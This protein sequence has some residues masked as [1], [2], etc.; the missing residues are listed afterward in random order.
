MAKQKYLPKLLLGFV[1]IVGESLS[2]SPIIV[3][4]EKNHGYG[5]SDLLTK[6]IAK[7]VYDVIGNT[8]LFGVSSSKH[9]RSSIKK[10]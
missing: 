6:E 7:F 10:R 4:D 3:L 2:V 8:I 9:D 5:F 1:K